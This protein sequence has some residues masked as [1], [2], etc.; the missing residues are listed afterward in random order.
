MRPSHRRVAVLARPLVATACGLALVATVAATAAADRDPSCE[1][2]PD[3]AT[4]GL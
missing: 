4:R 1:W 2:M 3:T